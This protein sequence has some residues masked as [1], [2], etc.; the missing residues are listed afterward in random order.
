MN[1]E[2]LEDVERVSYLDSAITVTRGAEEDVKS[3]LDE[4]RVA[5]NTVRPV[6]N[7]PSI[8]TKNQNAHLHCKLKL[9]FSM[10]QKPGK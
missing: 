6:W 9:R 10:D 8:S 7:A 3:R 2:D 4:A 1:G 5:F